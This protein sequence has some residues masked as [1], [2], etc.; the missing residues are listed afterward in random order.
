M[1]VSSI[2]LK[3]PVVDETTEVA[4]GYYM[5]RT[6]DL[7]NNT[8]N[9]ILLS[10]LSALP[11]ATMDLRLP[12]YTVPYFSRDTY[13][14]TESWLYSVNF[15]ELN[16]DQVESIFWRSRMMI[17]VYALIAG[18]IVYQWGLDLYG[19]SAALLALLFF[20]FSPNILAHAGISTYD[21]GFTMLFFAGA[22][23]LQRLL[24]APSLKWLLLTGILTGMIL[25]AKNTGPL[26]LVVVV[27]LTTL[28]F[29]QDVGTW[30]WLPQ[31]IRQHW[32]GRIG[33][34]LLSCLAI[35]LIAWLVLNSAYGFQGTFQPVSTYFS[36][37]ADRSGIPALLAELPVPFPEAYTDAFLYRLSH[38][39]RGQ[40][41]FLLGQYTPSLAYH[42]VAFLTKVP[43]AMLTVLLIVVG[44]TV[45]TKITSLRW[46]TKELALLIPAVIV[47]LV[48]ASG[49]I[50]VGFRHILPVMPFLFIFGGKI[51]SFSTH[52][53]IWFKAIVGS[54]LAWY[55]ISSV[56]IYP[57]Y[58]AY[59][60]ELV[61]GPERGYHVLVDSNL[62]WGQDL[63]G[64]K[65]YMEEEQIEQIKLSYFGS[66]DPAWYDLQFDYLPSIGLRQPGPEG[67]WWYEPDYIEE[68]QSTTGTIAVSATN[69]QG[70]LFKDRQCFAWLRE[71][72]PVAKI[73][74]SI[75]VYQI[76]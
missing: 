73:G 18:L 7:S 68:C 36:R 50:K 15:L 31:R 17:L 59:F 75:F 20:T 6:G 26:F 24:F 64:L 56:G 60:N 74:Y 63:K 67:L 23:C 14:D 40:R 35:L 10:T 38:A 29:W 52:L 58:L 62:D 65:A 11:L 76:E 48:V 16:Q 27:A 4:A 72:E 54:L 46:T 44:L 53:S 61:G 32:L 33:S 71:Y 39:S 19:R 69:L 55:V 47:F 28:T 9:P 1:V 51:A 8:G 21:M 49:S 43:L 37:L 70:V 45:R 13:S 57:H 42:P 5:L 34:Y 12:A 22:Y 30:S 2:S 41:T 3:S 25:L 66:A